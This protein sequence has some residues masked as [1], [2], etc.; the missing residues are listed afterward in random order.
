MAGFVKVLGKM[1]CFL[2]NFC[3]YSVFLTP[4]IRILAN[5]IEMCLQ[6]VKLTR[7]PFVLIAL[8]EN[9]I[10]TFKGRITLTFSHVARFTR[11]WYFQWFQHLLE[12][13]DMFNEDTYKVYLVTS[14]PQVGPGNNKYITVS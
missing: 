4:S 13:E 6:L 10:Q 14:S 8:S 1:M 11:H 5:G 2:V 3:I 12:I 9:R 7:I